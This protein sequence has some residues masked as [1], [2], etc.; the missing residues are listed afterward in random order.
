MIFENGNPFNVLVSNGH[1]GCPFPCSHTPTYSLHWLAFSGY[2]VMWRK[3]YYSLIRKWTWHSSCRVSHSNEFRLW[4]DPRKYDEQIG[5]LRWFFRYFSLIISL[6]PLY[7]FKRKFSIR[8]ISI[9]RIQWKRSW[10]SLSTPWLW[11]QSPFFKVT[12]NS[13][14]FESG[15]KF[16][17]LKLEN[18]HLDKFVNAESENQSQKI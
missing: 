1:I 12:L 7:I 2:C 9:R 11:F 4:I 3:F 14:V 10:G 5:H 18:F 16:E 13:R 17:E 15:Y 8:L 6:E